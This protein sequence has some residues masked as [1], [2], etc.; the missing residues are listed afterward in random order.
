MILNMKELMIFLAGMVLVA[1]AAMTTHSFES[2]QPVN[3]LEIQE[4]IPEVKESKK[5]ELGSQHLHR[6]W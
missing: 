1:G 3:R 4:S 2:C 5:V 6:D